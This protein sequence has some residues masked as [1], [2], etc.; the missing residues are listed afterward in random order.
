V[1]SPRPISVLILDDENGIRRSIKPFRLELLVQA[2]D[3]ASRGERMRA[4]RRI[5]ALV[6]AAAI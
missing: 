3:R 4:A 2:I 1:A 6:V 5:A